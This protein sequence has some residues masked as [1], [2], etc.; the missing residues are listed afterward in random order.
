VPLGTMFR[1]G[2]ECLTGCLVFQDVVQMPEKQS[3]KS[4]FGDESHMP[5]KT[6][7]PAHTAEV[8]RQVEGADVVEG[9]WVG[10]DSWFGSIGTA[11]ELLKL[12]KVHSTWVIKQNHAY[13]PM[14]VLHKLLISRHGNNPAGHWVVMTVEISGEKLFA[15][16][17]AWS[18]KGVSY[19]VSTCGKTTPCP[20]QYSTHFE[21][22]FGNIQSRQINRPDFAHFLYDYLPLI[23]E[24]NKQ[25][26]AI[27]SLEKCW[28]TRNCWF[29]LMVTLVGMCV[30]DLHRLWRNHKYGMHKDASDDDGFPGDTEIRRF[31]DLICANLRKRAQKTLS[32]S[33]I[34]ARTSEGKTPLTRIVHEDGS[35]VRDCTDQQKEKRRSVGTSRQRKCFICRK[36][37]SEK[38]TTMYRDTSFCCSVC[39]MPLCM[40]DRTTD[41]MENRPLTC[42]QE[43]LTSQNAVLGCTGKHVIGTSLPKEMQV[44]IRKRRSP[45]IR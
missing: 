7:I 11:L 38:R 31:S 42:L 15:V 17:Y 36:Y 13:F 4:F 5:N 25:R 22:D 16:A 45:R 41:E 39:G 33:Q 6:P 14:Q 1:N 24:H 34:A 35:S 29:R 43:H 19:F 10:G 20:I 21:D 23:D 18:Q 8:L 37:L 2:V 28:P 3:L 44:V 12:K 30:V 26:Q 27:L 9:G 32:L 40:K